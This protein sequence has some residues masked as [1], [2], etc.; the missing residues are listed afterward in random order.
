MTK[1]TYCVRYRVRSSG[2]VAVSNFGS[3][4]LRAIFVAG[5]SAWADIQHEWVECEHQPEVALELQ[6]GL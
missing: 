6:R 4:M 1:T 5:L 2:L 3:L